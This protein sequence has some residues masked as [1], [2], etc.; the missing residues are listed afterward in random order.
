MLHSSNFASEIRCRAGA[1]NAATMTRPISPIAGLSIKK[2][3]SRSCATTQVRRGLVLTGDIMRLA[4]GLTVTAIVAASALYA[5]SERHT[6]PLQASASYTQ[7][8]NVATLTTS[9]VGLVAA[10]EQGH[11]FYSAD[12]G[13]TWQDAKMPA[14]QHYAQINQVSFADANE[15]IAV[16]H[17]GLILR[18]H[19]GGKSWEETHFVGDGSGN[20]IN[21]AARLPD[22]S[23]LALGAFGTALRSI[24]AGK[25][26]E[27]FTFDS[28]ED[29]HF[30]KIFHSAD[31]QQ[32]MIVGE[33]GTALKSSDG[34]QTWNT[35]APFYNGSFYGGASLGNDAWLVYG[36][37]GNVYRSTDGGLS[38]I[39]SSVPHVF[40]LL[41]HYVD[42]AGAIYLVGLNGTILKS[43]DGGQIFNEVRRGPQAA[44]LAMLP[45]PKGGWLIATEQGVRHYGADF[46]LDGEKTLPPV[47]P[48]MPQAAAEPAA[49]AASAS[50][51]GAAQ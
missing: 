44:L 49:S 10:G 30:N 46:R 28:V 35:I 33:A 34:G 5:F 8:M 36:M 16:G 48:A 50:E 9:G 40:S 14:K 1:V 2:S 12:G 24:D 43:E 6:P 29:R 37:R 22:G 31:G 11:I 3:P 15:G 4:V 23:W 17:E 42:D 51:T 26:W 32:W 13:K 38:W 20:S 18:S 47:P 27:K 19:D 25:S 45:D 39:K 21:T 41:G 7:H